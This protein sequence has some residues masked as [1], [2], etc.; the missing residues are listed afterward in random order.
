MDLKTLTDAQL[1]SE[2]VRRNQARPA[3][4]VVVRRKRRH[5]V[6]TTV[7]DGKD[8]TVSIVLEV[9]GPI[10]RAINGA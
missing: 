2:L 9:D 5:F 1:L 10:M 8:H 4:G 7:A 3:D 6:E